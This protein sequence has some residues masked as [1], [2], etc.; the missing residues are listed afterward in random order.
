MRVLVLENY[1]NTTLGL[2]GEALA[3]AG[4]ECR[5]ARMQLGDT[6]P[7]APEGFD[8]LVLLGGGQSALDDADCPY[9]PDEAKLARAFGEAG[10]PVLGICLGAQLV[11]R[12]Y[13]AENILGR[14]IEFGWHEVR[15]TEAGR[16]DPVLAALGEAAPLFHWHS[17][18]F[19]LPSGA[20]HLAESD[21]TAL[22][23]FRIDSAVYGIQFH[24]EAGTELV[25]QWNR[26]CRDEILACA[27]DWFARWPREA[28]RH[29]AATDAAGRVLARAWVN[30]LR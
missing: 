24:F 27:P 22:Q 14:P 4:A 16:S 6:L 12:A 15:T 5:I 19:T 7:T 8:G 2:V 3:A 18:T 1:P 10:K 13:G 17:D 21:A 29:G 11:A 26:D 9:L 20:V 30:L 28:A 25:S 23:A